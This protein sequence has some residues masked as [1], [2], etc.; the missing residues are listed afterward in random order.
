LIESELGKRASFYF[1]ITNDR[2]N[3]AMS[4]KVMSEKVMDVK[5]EAK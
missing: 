4:E 2:T 1:T 3:T 5:E